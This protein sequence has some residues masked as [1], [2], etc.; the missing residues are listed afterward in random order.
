MQIT[1]VLIQKVLPNKIL[2]TLDFFFLMRWIRE[3]SWIVVSESA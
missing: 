1:A 3:A 2:L